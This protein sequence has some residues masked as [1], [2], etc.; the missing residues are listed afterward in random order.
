MTPSP[1]TST[2]P[3][4]AQ[5]RHPRTA[6]RAYTGH[7]RPPPAPPPGW[8]NYTA[9]LISSSDGGVTFQGQFGRF[10]GTNFGAL[11]NGANSDLTAT[12]TQSPGRVQI[13]TSQ[14]NG[15]SI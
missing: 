13:T 2:S 9:D 12:G 11:N 7:T 10:G 5:H 3:T 14:G 8:Q 4:H 1:A 15:G 6:S